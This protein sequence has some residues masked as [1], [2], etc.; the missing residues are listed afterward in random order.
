MDALKVPVINVL[1]TITPWAFEMQVVVAVERGGMTCKQAQNTNG[2]QGRSTALIWL[3]KHGKIKRLKAKE[4]SA[5]ITK[6][7]ELELEDER[8][9]SLLLDE[10]VD[11]LDSE[12]GMGLRKKVYCQGT[13]ALK[14]KRRSA[15]VVFVCFLVSVVRPFIKGSTAP[16]SIFWS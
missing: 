10:V 16:S 9:R 3:R 11:A 13:G 6:R 8:L 14:L 2:I 1:R 5:Q 15:L 12:H 7:L 4:L